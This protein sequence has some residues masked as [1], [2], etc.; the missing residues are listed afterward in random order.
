[1]E[2]ML[3]NFGIFLGNKFQGNPLVPPRIVFVIG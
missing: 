1:M 2:K 3:T